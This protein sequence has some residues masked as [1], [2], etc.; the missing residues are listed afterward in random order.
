MQMMKVLKRTLL[1]LCA[2]AF[3]ATFGPASRASEWDKKTFVTFS[4]AVEIPGQVLPA[5]TYLFQL[6]NSDS[7]RH[8]VQVWNEDE[9]LLIATILTIPSVRLETPGKTAFTFEERAGAAPMALKTWF[10]PGDTVGQEFVYF[11][12]AY[13]SPAYSSGNH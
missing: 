4:D 3:L 8:I 1:G 6:A 13:H 12:T 2:L 10:Y 5:G 7:N 11:T 9:T